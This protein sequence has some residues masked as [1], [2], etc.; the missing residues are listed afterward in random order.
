M[1]DEFLRNEIASGEFV[2]GFNNETLS[3]AARTVVTLPVTSSLNETYGP[4]QYTNPAARCLRASD[5]DIDLLYAA[6]AGHGL[7]Y[8]SEQDTTVIVHTTTARGTALTTSLTTAPRSATPSPASI[9]SASSTS[10]RWAP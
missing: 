3:N 2:R 8:L 10:N 9:P 1:H 5:T 6:N 7:Y 4:P